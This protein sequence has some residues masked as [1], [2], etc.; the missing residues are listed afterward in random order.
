MATVSAIA[1]AIWD[2]HWSMISTVFGAG[3]F[4]LLVHIQIIR[5][6]WRRHRLKK[7]FKA[8]FL[9][10]SFDR[11][12]MGYIAQ[13]NH[14]HYVDE[15]VVPVNSEVIIQIVLEP[16]LSFLQHELYFGCDEHLVDKNKPVATEYFVP[17]VVLGVRK[18]GKPDSDHPGHYTDYNGFYHVRERYLYSRDVRVIGFKLATNGPGLFAAQIYTV[19]ED[20]RGRADLTIRVE[21]PVKTR[22]RCTYK[23]HRWQGCYVSPASG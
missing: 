21:D 6:W 5:P 11:F 18:S 20:V 19:T 4:F 13:D 3:A 23:A 12:R 10:T 7:P 14:E 15:L 8:H 9:I 16:K 22:M 2:W 1:A 17:F